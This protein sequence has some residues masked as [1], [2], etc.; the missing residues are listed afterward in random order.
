MLLAKLQADLF[1]F[2]TVTELSM[3]LTCG[4]TLA[5]HIVH[6]VLP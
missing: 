3:T 2:L 4:E 6:L 5:F 1:I